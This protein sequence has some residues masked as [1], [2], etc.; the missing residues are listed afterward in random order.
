VLQTRLAAKEEVMAAKDA[1]HAAEVIAAKDAVIE[2][3][4][5]KY[6][7]LLR[8][9]GQGRNGLTPKRLV[10]WSTIFCKCITTKST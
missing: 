6:V 4:Q 2:E 3:V 5:S 10:D 8:P 1:V 7:S 9:R